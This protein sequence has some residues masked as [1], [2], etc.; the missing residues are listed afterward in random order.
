MENNHTDETESFFT[1][2]ESPPRS[3]VISDT[4]EEPTFAPLF[5]GDGSCRG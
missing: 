4:E 2:L 5:P 3:A 1:L